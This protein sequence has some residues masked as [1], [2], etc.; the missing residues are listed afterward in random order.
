[1]VLILI[2]TSLLA[3]LWVIQFANSRMNQM[4]G[5][6]GH[7][8]PAMVGPSALI[9]SL[10]PNYPYSIIPGGAYTPRELQSAHDG[11]DLIHSH[12][13]GFNVNTA[14][15]VRLMD[16]RFQYVS[17]RLDDHVFWT[18]RKLRIPR[19]ELLLTDGTSYA[20]AR[21]GNRLSDNPHFAATSPH[22]PDAKSLNRPSLSQ[23]TLPGT[24]FANP[25]TTGLPG[26]SLGESPVPSSQST[27]AS[28]F[29]P[30]AL[31]PNPAGPILSGPAFTG[32]G[33]LPGSPVLMSGLPILSSSPILPAK[34]NIPQPPLTTPVMPPITTS[35]MP[36][37]PG[38][39]VPEPNTIYLFVTTLII[40]IW[41]MLRPTPENETDRE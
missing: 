22:E 4:A 12:Y 26:V 33:S 37:D 6:T 39:P 5:L 7:T 2:G 30:V 34:S 15:L 17:Y 18:K 10:R 9:R 24:A 1:M 23:A 8:L 14:K 25:P 19:G 41:A 28:A 40:S 11:D 16:D 21:C 29:G 20:R 13:S 32:I 3:V 36:A 27:G 35:E 31:Q 38:T